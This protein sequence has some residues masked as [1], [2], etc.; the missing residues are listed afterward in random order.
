MKL[1]KLAS[2]MAVGLSCAYLTQCTSIPTSVTP[3]LPTKAN[4]QYPQ[5]RTHQ[6]SLDH[7]LHGEY[8]RPDGLSGEQVRPETAAVARPDDGVDNYRH[9]RMTDRYR[10]MERAVGNIDADYNSDPIYGKDNAASRD[11]NT[12]GSRTEQD[13]GDSQL[14]DRQAF[15][16]EARVF[17]ATT[18]GARTGHHSKLVADGPLD[19]RARDFIKNAPRE[20]A[21]EELTSW[22]DTQD[23][24]MQDYLIKDPIWQKVK[25]NLD[26]LLDYETVASKEKF[27]GV[28]TI[29]IIR[30]F[31]HGIRVEL[32]DIY[33]EKRTILNEQDFRYHGLGG[34]GYT[35]LPVVSPEGT[36][37]AYATQLSGADDDEPTLYVKKIATGEIVAEIY[38][39]ET[40]SFVWYDDDSFIYRK[41][42]EILRHDIGVKRQ[43]DPIVLDMNRLDMRLG[44]EANSPAFDLYDASET[45]KNRYFAIGG[46]MSISTF[47]IVDMKTG[48]VHQIHDEKYFQKANKPYAATYVTPAKLVHF[49]PKTLD[50]WF[51]STENTEKGEIL[52]INLKTPTKRQVVIRTPAGYDFM[53]DAAYYSE[54]GGYFLV[55]FSKDV[56]DKVLLISADGKIAKD[57]TPMELGVADKLKAHI[58]GDKAK[59]DSEKKDGSDDDAEESYVRFDYSN[60]VNPIK[61]YKYSVEKD[62]FIDERYP[63]PTPKFKSDD[64]EIKRVFYRSKDNTAI[65]MVIAHKKGIKLDGTNPTLLYAY[66]GFGVKG[67]MAFSYGNASYLDAGLVYAEAFIR[68][69]GEYGRD[70]HK[71][72]E[73][74]NRDRQFEDVAAAADFLKE[75]G[76]ADSKHLA[77]SGWSQGGFM[78]GAMLT[79]YPEKFRAA[80]PG[81][82]VFDMFRFDTMDREDYFMKEYG[83]SWGPKEQ[84]DAI[85]R[86]SPYQNVKS[87]VCY[88][89]TLVVVPTRDDRVWPAHSYKFTAALQEHQS[90]DNPVLMFP[91]HGEGHNPITRQGQVD[92]LH[93]TIAFALKE[94]GVTDVPKNARPDFESLK[95]QAQKDEEAKEQAKNEAEW[96]KNRQEKD[97]K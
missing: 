83:V 1:T 18:G 29:E 48:Y 94:I 82:G 27:D 34:F 43:N 16:S 15:R 40:D 95:T 85:K 60:T 72:A 75:Q 50:V 24:M 74:V 89:S 14:N 87:G 79:L 20:Q 17:F 21:S 31:K 11:R 45:D 38:K 91:V 78:T 53:K 4:E 39:A 26:E 57:L 59:S 42:P 47:F 9:E 51:I 62:Q 12:F 65:P 54:N 23:Q 96:Q 58:V 30:D 76:Y 73:S 19:N 44:N 35:G 81:A 52:K 61:R 32:T 84:F 56:S 2:M 46:G 55:S 77:L 41:F 71:A 90:C 86:W 22:I 7:F 13:L 66:G 37:I 68:G 80:I 97:S 67:D 25:G 63:F 88:P 10:W 28:G 3:P 36:Y 33:G 6:D 5:V 64:Y 70:W 93:R 92:R 69:G 8:G 49:D